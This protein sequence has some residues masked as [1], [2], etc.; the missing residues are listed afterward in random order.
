M[1]YDGFPRVASTMFRLVRSARQM[2]SSGETA[3]SCVMSAAC[4]HGDT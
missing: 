3:L 2:G 4:T 1:Q